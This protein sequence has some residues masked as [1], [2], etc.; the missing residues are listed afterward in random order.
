MAETK[1]PAER[2]A[3]LSPQKQLHMRSFG[4]E[5]LAREDLKAMSLHFHL[6]ALA[7]CEMMPEGDDLLATLNKIWEG[8][9]LA[10][11]FKV[12]N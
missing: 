4:Y 7:M 9:N 10:V 11:N 8:K 2:L 12:Y 1:T 3:A 5:H 6:N